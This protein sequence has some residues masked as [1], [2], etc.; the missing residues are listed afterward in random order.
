MPL[1]NENSL[2]VFKA[3]RTDKN[4]RTHTVALCLA[5]IGFVLNLVAYYPG[6]M[7]P[8]S[9]DVYAQSISHH[10]TDSHPPIMAGLWSVFNN[11]YTGSLIMLLFQLGLF[12]G[13]FYL[14]A[15]TWFSSR[16]NQIFLFLG[17]L[18]EPFI[19]NF[20]AYII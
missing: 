15:T 1:I 14:L 18:L 9:L 5:L 8:D 6:F 4:V 7:S 2:Q 12:W 17:L 13:S 20:L 3:I 19:Q 16:R 11:F 10:Y